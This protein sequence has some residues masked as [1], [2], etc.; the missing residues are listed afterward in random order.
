MKTWTQAERYQPLESL[1]AREYT[2]LA[3]KVAHAPWRQAFHIQP[4][5]GLLND[6]NG[7]CYDGTRYHLFYQWF[8]LGAAHGLKYWRALQ[9]PDLVHFTDYGIAIAPDTEADSHGAYSGSAI[10]NSDGTLTIAYTGNHRTPDWIRKPHQ[11]TATYHPDTGALTR[12]IPF[13]TDSPSGYTEHVRDP[14][15]WRDEHGN[16]FTILG[17]QR[18]DRTGC[19]LITQ[20]GRLLGEL[21]TTLTLDGCYMWECPDLF[22]LT[23]TITGETKTVLTI[24]PQGLP[25][26]G[27]ANRN[28]YQCSYAVGDFDLATLTFTHGDL[29]TLD[30]GFEYYA[31]QSCAG[32]NG[33]RIAIAWM[34][35]PDTAYPTDEHDWQG[36]LTLPRTLTLENGVLKQRPLAALATLRGETITTPTAI[37]HGELLLDNPNST[38]FTLDLFADDNHRT[39]LQF[40]GNRLIFDRSQSGALPTITLNPIPAGKA[41]PIRELTIAVQQLRLFI[42]RSSLE[43]FINDGDAV[44]TARIFAPPTANRIHLDGNAHLIGWH[45]R[46]T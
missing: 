33:S 17:A 16:L 42:D 26:D 13:L 11:L 45:Y 29:I 15:L 34:G 28:L 2:N 31:Q 1:N 7:F 4:P 39:R 30:D 21:K 44:M 38:P 6:P 5:T 14:K 27:T 23:D 46:P 32:E 18:N 36:C 43:I 41:N 20:N 40:D 37:T 9:S 35:L 19:A 22:P 3:I 10:A 25:A 12:D 24:S 8:P